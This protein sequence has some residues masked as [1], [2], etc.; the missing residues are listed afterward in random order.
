MTHS[1]QEVG[2]W[3][4]SPLALFL[5]GLA[6]GCAPTA[7]LFSGGRTTLQDR[8][9]VMVGTAVRL[10]TGDLEEA[11]APTSAGL[12]P[13]GALRV[14][15]SRY[16]DVGVQ[17][18]G[19]TARPELRVWLPT[20][21]DT[22]S[23]GFVLAGSVL[24]GVVDAGRE[25]GLRGAFG[26]DLSMVYTVDAGSLVEVWLGPRASFLHLTSR[27]GVEDT[28][29]SRFAAGLTIGAA[30]GLRRLSALVELTTLYEGWLGG[31]SAGGISFVPAAAIRL[32]L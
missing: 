30:F 28:A 25:E 23:Y 7:P 26:V 18:Q 10:P 21:E 13:G 24:G 29:R 4:F 19:A 15:A 1:N 20:K 16:V 11:P 12:A 31:V 8:T 3:W 32:R 5:V 14:A 9:D 27:L 17:V 2:R 6:F 22:T